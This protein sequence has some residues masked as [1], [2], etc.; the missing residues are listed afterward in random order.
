MIKVLVGGGGGGSRH[1][2]SR[3]IE[4]GVQLLIGK[5][6]PNG[7][8]PQVS[9]HVYHRQVIY[10]YYYYCSCYLWRRVPVAQSFNM[11]RISIWIFPLSLG[12]HCRRV[13][14]KLRY[15]LHVLQKCLPCLDPGTLLQSLPPQPVFWEAQRC[16]GLNVCVVLALKLLFSFSTVN[17]LHLG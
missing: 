5:Q 10:Y 12:E 6:Q 2:D 3:A 8:W 13:Q 17:H 7:D 11:C 4:R 9:L 16:E 15:K 14:Q 1:P